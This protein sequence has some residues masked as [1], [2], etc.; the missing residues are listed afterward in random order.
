MKFISVLIL[1]LAM[2]LMLFGCG[3]EPK[4]LHCDRCGKELTVDGDSN[5]EEDWIIFCPACE[6]EAFGDNP[7]V[8]EG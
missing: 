8:Q 7:V 2:M 3:K 5:M 6:E 4:L 1:C